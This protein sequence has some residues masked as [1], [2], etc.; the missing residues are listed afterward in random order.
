MNLRPSLTKTSGL[1][2]VATIAAAAALSSPVFTQGRAQRPTGTTVVN[3][4]EAVAG[5]VLV[6]YRD[7]VDRGDRQNVNN[8]VD[9]DVDDEI[10]S[11]GFRRL[12]SR[13]FDTAAMLNFL[14]ADARVAYVEPN[15][16][17]HAIATPN[18]PSFGMLWGLQNTG[19]TLGCGASCY[20]TPTGTA[21]ADISATLA[22]DVSTGSRANVV[23]VVDTGID[24]NHPD[25]AANVW[26]APA[27]FSVTVGGLVI[28]CAAGT[29]G[30][31]AFTNSCNPLDDN[32]HG[33]HTSG[34]IGATGNNGVGVAGVNWVASIMG[35]KFLNAA[36]SGTTANA[37]NAIEFAVQ[38]KTVLGADANV[39]VLS[40]SWGG[41]G[42]SQALLDEINKANASDMLFVAAAGNNGRNNDTTPNYPSNYAA[43]NVVAVAATDNND[44][45][46]RFSNYGATMVHL[47]APGVDVLST[48]RNNT[49]K[50]FSGTSMA[51]PHVAGAAALVLSA[52]ALDTAGLKSILLNSIDLIPSMSGVTI[53][54][55]RLNVNQAI[56]ACSPTPDFALSVTPDSQSVEQGASTIYTATVTPSG[57]FTGTV[58][59]SV[60]DLPADGTAS[61]DPASVTTS[62]S[63]TLTVATAS[64]TPAGI[65]AITITATSGTLTY[66][67]VVTLEVTEPAAAAFTVAASPRR[68]KIRR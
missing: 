16:I 52:C 41:G 14:R 33:S 27:A 1:V 32:D 20:G 31:N 56:R 43:P 15:Y 12:H 6:K 60:A 29:H 26:S 38:A 65:Y 36:G 49:Y 67:T 50:Y 45:I 30:F 28:N 53:T 39:R 57:G 63:S 37:I 11:T 2:V 3:G 24:Y 59:F 64:T 22:W 46:A 34:T 23:A 7:S 55:G 10:G 35:A 47:G 4:A 54:G 8:Q 61:F 5:E 18:D 68:Q 17:V 9:A 25:L 44:G 19:Q 48:T 66:S 40:N 42:F 51:T 13:S 58:T 21:G 62:G